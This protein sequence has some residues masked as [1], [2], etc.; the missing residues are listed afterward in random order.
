MPGLAEHVA[1]LP[2]THAPGGIRHGDG[3]DR[4][5]KQAIHQ[6]APV[7]HAGERVEMRDAVQLGLMEYAKKSGLTKPEQ[8]HLKKSEA[9][10]V[11]FLREFRV[12][13]G[14]GDLGYP[15][16][17]E[18]EDGRVFVVYWMNHEKPGE[19]GFF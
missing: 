4:L 6:Q 16:A 13:G 2:V 10:G 5:C 3:A 15:S 9:E 17:L 8:G 7:G 1:D 11:K 12:D 18:F 19:P 14:N